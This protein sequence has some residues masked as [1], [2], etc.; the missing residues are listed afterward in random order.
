MEALRQIVLF[1]HLFAAVFWVGELIFLALV[2]GPYARTLSSD[3]RGSLFRAVGSR[4]LPL[5][6]V[7]IGVLVVTGLLNVVLMGIPLGDLLSPALYHTP[8]G[9]FL[10]LKLLAVLLMIAVSGIHDFVIAG[11]FR[12]LRQASAQLP[13]EDQKRQL[14]A[15]HDLARRLGQINAVLAVLILFFAAGLVVY[16][17]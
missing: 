5:V 1:I 8:F 6:W 4:S 3:Q 12:R 15:Y 16:G 13:S 17:G 9:F 14:A 10:G 7:A 2:V 11:K